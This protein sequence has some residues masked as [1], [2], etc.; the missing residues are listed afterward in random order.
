MQRGLQPDQDDRQLY[1]MMRV[2]G[3][4]AYRYQ[5]ILEIKNVEPMP[6]ESDSEDQ[7]EVQRFTNFNEQLIKEL[8]GHSHS[9]ADQT[10]DDQ[11]NEIEQEKK[12]KKRKK[13]RSKKNKAKQGEVEQLVAE[14]ASDSV[15]TQV[16][17]VEEPVDEELEIEMVL[18][19]QRLEVSYVDL[20]PF[21]QQPTIVRR[22]KP[23]FDVEWITQLRQKLITKV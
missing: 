20:Y 18:F 12:R 5:K 13:N 21:L 11:S 15:S 23:N 3:G 16:T 22:I 4:I 7:E 17:V 8:I 6:D 2:G 19:K 1:E 14:D 9:H 10:E